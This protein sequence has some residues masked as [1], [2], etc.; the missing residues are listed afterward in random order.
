MNIFNLRDRNVPTGLDDYGKNEIRVNLPGAG[1]IVRGDERKALAILE[2]DL[3]KVENDGLN[4]SL[5]AEIVIDEEYM[6]P[7]ANW[8]SNYLKPYGVIPIIVGQ[9]GLHRFSLQDDA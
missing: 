4:L 7:L 1:R 5:A 3:R 9:R 2:E 8:L 6:W